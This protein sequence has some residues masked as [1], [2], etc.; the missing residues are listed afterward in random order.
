M[1]IYRHI[2]EKVH[3]P[4]PVDEDGR[5]YEIHHVDGDRS[6]N[7][8]SNLIALSIRDHYEVHSSQGD[9]GAAWAIARR[10]GM[11]PEELSKLATRN[12]LE[13]I[14][15]GTHHFTSSDWQRENQLRRVR[16]GSHH[17]Q[18]GDV[19][20]ESHRRKLSDGTSHLIREETCPHCGKVGKGPMMKRWHGDRCK[21]IALG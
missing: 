13:W 17:L 1:R 14:A 21:S 7:D 4:I 8:P 6:N 11:S 2:Y 12:N 5:T 10:M 20:R 16:T 3:G 18:T 19:Q 15:R 9:W